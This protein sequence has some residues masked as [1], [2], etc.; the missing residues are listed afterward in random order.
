MVAREEILHTLDILGRLLKRV[1]PESLAG[2]LGR[3]RRR[4]SRVLKFNLPRGQAAQRIDAAR[5]AH[6]A[7][8][9]ATMRGAMAQATPMNAAGGMVPALK[10]AIAAVSDPRDVLITN[11]AEYVPV[12]VTI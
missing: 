5:E 3:E 6:G 1:P 7:P 4:A 2:A 11:V 8:L 12:V 10:D 9:S